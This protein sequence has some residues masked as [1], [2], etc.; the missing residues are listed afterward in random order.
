MGRDID[1]ARNELNFALSRFDYSEK[2]RSYVCRDAETHRTGLH[3]YDDPY[4]DYGVLL[5][6]DKDGRIKQKGKYEIMLE[7]ESYQ[8]KDFIKTGEV[9]V[10]KGDYLVRVVRVCGE[11]FAGKDYEEKEVEVF[12]LIDVKYEG[13]ETC[14]IE[15]DSGEKIWEDI[16][17]RKYDLCT[18]EVGSI[19]EKGGV[20][21][22]F[23]N[24][25]IE[26][27]FDRKL[28]KG[29]KRA[30]RVPKF[31]DIKGYDEW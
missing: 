16:R 26:E 13:F 14:Y 22:P 9:K 11:N 7:G 31:E 5:W 20:W 4:E 27:T 3:H 8:P 17:E 28:W 24:K 10:E 29:V 15:D 18:I 2:E 30:T 12:E 19:C 21:E 1:F 6:L 25:A 23:A